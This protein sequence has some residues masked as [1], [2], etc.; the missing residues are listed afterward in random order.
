MT[1]D[2]WCPRRTLLG[3]KM[4]HELHPSGLHGP[5]CLVLL[6]SSAQWRDS[7]TD[8]HTHRM[9]L[10]QWS[11]LCHGHLVSSDWMPYVL[12]IGLVFSFSLLQ[13]I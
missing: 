9:A 3:S 4:S 6:Q 10:L 11:L 8:R 5:F 2:Q 1:I 12:I 7:G 13:F